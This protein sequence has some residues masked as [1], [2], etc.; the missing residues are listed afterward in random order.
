[1]PEWSQPSDPQRSQL[2]KGGCGRPF[3][4]TAFM[5]SRLSQVSR[6][7]RCLRYAPQANTLEGF[8]AHGSHPPVGFRCV[9]RDSVVG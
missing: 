4:G 5:P 3:F 7:N 8:S 9:A 2:R 6:L 1:M